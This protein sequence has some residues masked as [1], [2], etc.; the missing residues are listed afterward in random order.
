MP[1]AERSGESPQED[2][3][4]GSLGTH[5]A[6][7]VH[8]PV[9]IGELE[10]R[11]RAADACGATVNGHA[12]YFSHRRRPDTLDFGGMQSIRRLGV[13][14]AALF[15]AAACGT[16][17]P[18]SELGADASLGGGRPA[19]TAPS[20]A[21]NA[22]P[23]SDVGVSP[24][25]IQIGLIVSESGPLG[26]EA[27]SAPMY[28]ALA[29]FQALNK[30][31]G[32]DG[33]TVHVVVCDDGSTGS[34]NRD[35][36]QKLIQDDKVFA[37][38]GNSIFNYAAASYV[39]AA[40]VPDIGGQ[41]IGNEYDQYPHLYSVEGDSYPRTGQFVGYNGVLVG[42]TAVYH[43]FRVAVG[44]K[45]AGVVYYNQS[46]SQR[47]GELTVTGLHMEGYQV[48]QEQV[49]LAVPNFDAAAVDMKAHHVDTI[50]DALDTTGN[51]SLCKS[52]EAAGLTVKAKVT[53]V[54]NW[55]DSVRADFAGTPTCRNS[56]YATAQDRNYM[57]TQFPAVAR[58][59][60]DMQAA[61]PD[62]ANQL[63]MWEEEGWEAGDWFTAAA[64]SC[65][66]KLTRKCVEAFINRP[67][68]F[69]AEGLTT[70]S[71]FVVGS[72]TRP[73]GPDCMSVAQWQDAAYGGKGGWVTRTP[74]GAFVCYSDLP[75]ISYRP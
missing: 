61:Y 48:V 3:D 33:R 69:T 26:S 72:P 4:D 12:V 18:K 19:A 20:P 47:Y 52:M 62:R 41:P 56:I 73:T 64:S 58:F 53:T 28:G 23:S 68:P 55:T 63:S 60:A 44:G 45:V 40:D 57:D 36:A 30:R 54:Q 29:Y 24:T 75:R 32:I 65:G 50:F 39:S 1:P 74:N 34:G 35:C 27:L 46:D 43:F 13:V 6:Q 2:Q 38:V 42:G 66:A 59:R 16:R 21:G 71:S 70:G 15:L 31:G 51:V 37:F 67:Q 8:G 7:A 17:L 49:D 22:N 14:T 11:R 5:L 10:I 25:A 9:D